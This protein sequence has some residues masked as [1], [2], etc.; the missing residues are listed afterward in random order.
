M[1]RIR[2]GPSSAKCGPN[3]IVQPKLVKFERAWPEINQIWSDFDK[4]LPEIGKIPP[5]LAGDRP[6]LVLL[7]LWAKFDQNWSDFD[8]LRAKLDQHWPGGFDISAKSDF[9]RTCPISAKL[10][11]SL[12]C[13]LRAAACNPRPDEVRL[14]HKRARATGLPLPCAQP[15]RWGRNAAGSSRAC[16]MPGCHA[17][18]RRGHAG[19]GQV[20]PPSGSE[21]ATRMGACS[22]CLENPGTASR[23]SLTLRCMWHRSGWPVLNEGGTRPRAPSRPWY[24]RGHML[25]ASISVSAIAV[26]SSTPELHFSQHCSSPVVCP[27]LTL[28]SWNIVLRAWGELSTTPVSSARAKWVMTSVSIEIPNPAWHHLERRGSRLSCETHRNSSVAAHCNLGGGKRPMW[29]GSLCNPWWLTTVCAR[30]PSM[31]QARAKGY[32]TPHFNIDLK[33]AV[34][35]MAP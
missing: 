22:P 31:I 13:P 33:I 24:K 29:M 26:G 28:Q 35:G 25:A 8:Q 18:S 6:K 17:S 34:Y 21:R 5:N 3:S 20:C 1:A 2:P 11:G 30:R 14:R 4:I 9:A 16:V 19:G 10:S 12:P 32:G 7:R 15:P 23:H 27:A